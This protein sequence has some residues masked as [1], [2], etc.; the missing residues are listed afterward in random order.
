MAQ[1]KLLP[2]ASTGGSL[3]TVT[4]DNAK[5]KTLEKIIDKPISPDLRIELVDATNIFLSR[6]IFE[7]AAGPRADATKRLT[8]LSRAAN[9]FLSIL[10]E[11]GSSDARRYAE[12]LIER[13]LIDDRLPGEDR[14]DHVIGVTTSF[15][16]ACNLARNELASGVYGE[17]RL[18]GS[19]EG[20]IRRLTEILDREGMST[21]ARKDAVKNKSE[22]ASNFVLFIDELQKTVEPKFRRGTSTTDALAGAVHLARQVAKRPTKRTNKTRKS[23]A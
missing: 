2:I 9:Q 14:F 23:T 8:A 16:A 11:A 7:H 19:W 13:C 5:W 4:I 22:K 20:W 10:N 6:A 3:P 1:R 21:S 17:F 18:G 12:L 15:A